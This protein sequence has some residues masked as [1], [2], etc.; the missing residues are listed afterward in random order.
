MAS[1]RKRYQ[2]ST[3]ANAITQDH[4]ATITDLVIVD[5]PIEPQSIAEFLSFCF[6]GTL[7]NGQKTTVALP[8]QDEFMFVF[9]NRSSPAENPAFIER[10]QG[11][12]VSE[13]D[14]ARLC[15]VTKNIQSMKNRLYAGIAPLSEQRWVEKELDRPAN[16]DLAAQYLSAV[17]AVFEYLNQGPVVKSM[18]GT[19]NLISDILGEVDTI[20]NNARRERGEEGSVSIRALWTDYMRAH[21]E[22]MTERAHRWVLVYVNRL[23]APLLRQLAA[24]RPADFDTPDLEQWRTTNRLHILAEIAGVADYTIMIPMHGYHGYTPPPARTGALAEVT[25]HEW[26]KRRKAFGP[27]MKKVVRAAQIEDIMERGR[28]EG[29]TEHRVA[30]PVSLS[31]TCL[32]QIRC[33][34]KVRKEIRGDPVEPVPKEPWISADLKRLED[35]AARGYGFVI[36]RL[37]YGQSDDEWTAFRQKVEAHI[38]DWGRGQTGSALTKP[39]LKLHW[40]DGKDLGIPEDDPEAAKVHYNSTYESQSDI[41]FQLV[42]HIN[43]RAFLAIDSSSYASYTGPTYSAATGFVLPGDFTGFVVAIH[44]EYD[45][46][47]GPER[48]DETPGYYGQMRILG[49]LVWGDLYA[50]LSSQSAILEDLWPLAMEHPNQ[51][52]IGPVVPSVLYGWRLQNGIRGTLMRD[53]AGYATAKVERREWTGPAIL[54][55]LPAAARPEST[56]QP[57]RRFPAHFP[58]D[59]T[60]RRPRPAPANTTTTT[61]TIP[62]EPNSSSDPINTALRQWM[63]ADFARYTRARGAHNSA[64]MAEHMLRTQQGQMP[65][66]DAVRQ[67]MEREGVLGRPDPPPPGD[68]DG[69]EEDDVHY[70]PPDC[71]TQ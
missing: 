31:R 13:P 55:P 41:P 21:F 39:H 68:G 34:A 19:F 67:Q 20:I 4:N 26:A 3:T 10:M 23:R 18:R 32:L 29:P 53:M 37:I 56:S 48:P 7:P 70:E 35:P 11:C 36:Y 16:F 8:Q 42:D 69:H 12:I 62:S 50:M 60:P 57:R 25:S 64:I 46:A 63:L 61:P 59:D 54:P 2:H 15:D 27:Y 38:S 65:D 24:H 6:H 49:S 47:E 30:D 5:R 33:Q 66:F 43:Q 14:G 51:V 58:T 1:K 22:V 9:S 52:Y 71:P 28:T 40:R 17:I 45:P 44:A